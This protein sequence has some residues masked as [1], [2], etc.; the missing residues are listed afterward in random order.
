MKNI[1][2][3]GLLPKYSSSHVLILPCKPQILVSELCQMTD[4]RCRTIL[5]ALTLVSHQ[6]PCL[7]KTEYGERD[8]K[9]FMQAPRR[10]FLTLLICQKESI[11]Y[12]FLVELLLPA[13][14]T[15][16]LDFEKRSDMFLWV[17]RPVL[18]V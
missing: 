16:L 10:Q 15:P 13:H 17:F 18:E 11:C 1:R 3:S 6:V 9:I 5:L 7:G 4:L 14:W 8:N 12:Y 2:Q